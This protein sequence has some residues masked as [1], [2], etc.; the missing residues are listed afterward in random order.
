MSLYPGA[1]LNAKI[2]YR[3]KLRKPGCKAFMKPVVPWSSGKFLLV[4]W[5]VLFVG[6]PTFS[7][8]K[9]KNSFRFRFISVRSKGLARFN[10]SWNT[11]YQMALKHFFFWKMEKLRN[12]LWNM[13]KVIQQIGEQGQVLKTLDQIQYFIYK[14]KMHHFLTKTIAILVVMTIVM[15]FH[16]V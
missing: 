10:C 15:T 6:G 13:T 14:T 8:Y 2:S 3:Y 4:F 12:K 5:G 11:F 1:N 16:P 9:T 7:P